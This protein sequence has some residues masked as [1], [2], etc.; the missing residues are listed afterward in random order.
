MTPFVENYTSHSNILLV[1]DRV[2]GDVIAVR[3]ENPS[4]MLISLLTVILY[5]A[6]RAVK[7]GSSENKAPA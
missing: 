2:N 3:V 7:F 4:V 1:Y 5:Q 6:S